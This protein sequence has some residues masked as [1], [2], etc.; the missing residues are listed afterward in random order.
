MSTFCTSCGTASTGATFCTSCG[1]AMGTTVPAVAS[2]KE[3]PQTFANVADQTSTETEG[4]VTV[5]GSNASLKKKPL[6]IGAATVLF[7][8]VGI[9]AFFAGKSSV[10]LE[11]ERKTAYDSGYSVGESAGYDRGDSAGYDRG[12]SA[13]YGRGYAAG[14]TAG[15]ENVFN[16]AGYADHLIEFYPNNYYYRYGSTYVSKSGC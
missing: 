2:T 10:D 7:L 4:E 8:G 16:R 3:V 13:G 11:K 9:G 6:L 12:D 5:E 15:C 14:V 1:A